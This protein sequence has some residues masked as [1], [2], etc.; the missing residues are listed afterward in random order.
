MP[1]E[2]QSSNAF[3]VTSLPNLQPV[4]NNVIQ[5]NLQQ[6]VA[7]MTQGLLEMVTGGGIGLGGPVNVPSI[8]SSAVG[9]AGGSGG[10]FV[11]FP[12]TVAPANVSPISPFVFQSAPTVTSAAPVARAAGPSPLQASDGNAELQQSLE[13]LYRNSP[14]S[15]ALMD[16]AAANGVRIRVDTTGNRNILGFY[17]PNTNE[18]VV[19]NPQ[20]LSTIVHELTHAVTR[21]NG[22]SLTEEGLADVIGEI[23][24]AEARGIPLSQIQSRLPQTFLRDLPLYLRQNL[25][26]DNGQLNALNQIFQQAG[27]GQ[28]TQTLA[29][30]LPFN[31]VD[32][33]RNG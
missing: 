29:Q 10:S 31:Q 15:R 5:A 24:A 19:G 13:L 25:R 1:L 21:N 27:V 26:N 12:N 7:L 4:A 22:N 11:P 17:D 9:N 32:D 14:T 16:V 20:N 33:V 23:G 8:F 3:S 28:I 30:I 2:I 6:G 18:I